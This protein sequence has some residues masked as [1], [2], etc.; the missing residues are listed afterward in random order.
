LYL[1]YNRLGPIFIKNILN[2]LKF[3]EYIKVLDL[4]K[5]LIT[6][7]IMNDVANFDFVKSLQR[8]EAITNIDL[9]GNQGF[10]KTIKFK[11]SLIMIR[12]IDKL[13]AAGIFVQGSWFNKNVLMLNETINST[14]NPSRVASPDQDRA[15]S[16]E[17][18][19]FNIE[20]SN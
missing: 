10:D 18:S 4:R 20:L 11:L 9:R 14:I 1:Q 7:S 17:D 5:N 6:T 2:S 8:N 16:D 19:I 12:N 3:D 15:Q 13:R